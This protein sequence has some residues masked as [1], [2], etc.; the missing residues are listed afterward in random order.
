MRTRFRFFI[1]AGLSSLAFGSVQAQEV[2]G[3]TTTAGA[4][5]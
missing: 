3:G 1:A 2:K 5:N 4:P